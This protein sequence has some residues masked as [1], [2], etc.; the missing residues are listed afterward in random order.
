M[1]TECCCVPHST[2]WIKDINNIWRTWSTPPPPKS[3]Y[4]LLTDVAARQQRAWLKVAVVHVLFVTSNT[5]TTLDGPVEL[6]P[7]PKRTRFPT[8]V[9]ARAVRARER[10]S[11]SAPTSS[12]CVVNIYSIKIWCFSI[13]TSTKEDKI[14][15]GSGCKISTRNRESGCCPNSTQHIVNIHSITCSC[16]RV[17][18]SKE[19]KFTRRRT[20]EDG[21]VFHMG[22]P[23]E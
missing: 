22:P 11:C 2:Q 7:P 3:A 5:S 21:F 18:T 8:E 14:L 4:R 1:L 19:D 9:A 16:S 12:Q 10:E 6:S 17:S 23:S 20:A 13:P 15:W